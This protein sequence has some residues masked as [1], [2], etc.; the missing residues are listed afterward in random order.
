[1]KRAVPASRVLSSSHA[2]IRGILR[3]CGLPV[4][5]TVARVHRSPG[6][7]VP[8]VEILEARECPNQLLDPLGL[9]ANTRWATPR[10]EEPPFAAR[11]VMQGPA[12]LP[13]EEPTGRGS[14]P[15]EMRA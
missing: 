8:L 13:A 14:A 5:R 3:R 2:W 11:F 7:A 9:T 1:M 15:A 12:R 6:R 4:P 10:D